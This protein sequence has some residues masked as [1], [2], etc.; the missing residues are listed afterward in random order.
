MTLSIC[1]LNIIFV[2]NK[3]NVENVKKK[4]IFETR[5]LGHPC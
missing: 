3:C 5:G 2:N 4:H 1:V